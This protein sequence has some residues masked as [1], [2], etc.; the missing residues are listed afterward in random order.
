[1]VARDQRQ[2]C[3]PERVAVP[4][5]DIVPAYTS[6]GKQADAGSAPACLELAFNRF[7]GYRRATY[8]ELTKA[9]CVAATTA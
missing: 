2:P 8:A 1:M 4:D 5:E 7:G 9:L 6:N 3:C